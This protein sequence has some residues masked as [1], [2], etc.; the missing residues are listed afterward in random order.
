MTTN[1]SATIFPSAQFHIHEK[2][3]GQLFCTT[4]GNS[5]VVGLSSFLKAL[6]FHIVYVALMPAF[7]CKLNLKLWEP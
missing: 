7:D 2:D 4:C 5:D 6:I 1:M 3:N